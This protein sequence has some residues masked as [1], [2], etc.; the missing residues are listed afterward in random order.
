MYTG[1]VVSLDVEDVRLPNGV[2][3]TLE[4]V[5]H[6]GGAAVVALNARGEVC[7]LRQYR[8]VAGGWI[9]EVPAGKL[10]GQPPD[11]IARQELAEE[12]G[13]TA[14]TW[15]SLGRYLA[16]PGVF[17]EVVHLWLARD[18]V[19]CAAR[20]E[21]DEVF[22]VEWVPLDDACGRALRGEIE[23]GKS[24]VA[25]LRAASRLGTHVG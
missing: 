20:P 18:L 12:A 1:R 25:L 2:E 16:S 15:E 3:A 21:R 6:P 24:V 13:M 17:Q 11:V 23:D 14:G 4:I 19:P 10:D 8:H 9:W 7:L 5:R 22:E